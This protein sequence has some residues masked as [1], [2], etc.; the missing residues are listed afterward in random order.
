MPQSESITALSAALV[1]ACGELRNP[2]CDRTNPA[3]HSR[4][5]TLASVL[6]TVR[7]VLAAHHLVVSQ[8]VTTEQGRVCVETR[9]LHKSGEWLCSTASAA[10]DANIQ[11]MGGAITYLRRYTLTAMLGIVGDD[12]DDGESSKAP[13]RPVKA[14]QRSAP[15]TARPDTPAPPE[16]PTEVP[17]GYERCRVHAV[18]AKE[19][20]KSGKAYWSVE[21]HTPGMAERTTAIIFSSTMAG[22]LAEAVGGY[23]VLALAEAGDE[24]KRYLT[25]QEVV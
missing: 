23:V 11:R 7:P 10:A 5:A 2:P 15:P 22:R 25:I 12:D 18:T 4:Y 17:A 24:A 8:A 13:Q 14:A 20:K 21:L 6:D 3:Y 1:A 16:P 9:I 19:S